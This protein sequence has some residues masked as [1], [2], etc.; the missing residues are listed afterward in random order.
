MGWKIWTLRVF[1]VLYILVDSLGVSSSI[2]GMM[3]G[4]SSTMIS[5][6]DFE[7]DVDPAVDVPRLAILLAL[8]I[9]VIY[10]VVIAK[11]FWA[12]DRLLCTAK[13]GGLASHTAAK[14]LRSMGRMMVALWVLLLCLESFLPLIVFL[15]N[16]PELSVEF[17]PFD[18]KILLVLVG[19]T[20]WLLA[21]LVDEARAMKEE[22]AGVV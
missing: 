3:T 17:A 21:R 7:G 15:P 16:T 12:M 13:L 9:L 11:L 6:L 8:G 18:L 19:M 14:A 20:L 5:N 2:Y 10:L 4:D 1:F 22:L